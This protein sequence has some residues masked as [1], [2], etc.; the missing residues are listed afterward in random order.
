M[1]IVNI[2]SRNNNN[3]NKFNNNNWLAEQLGVDQRLNHNLHRQYSSGTNA[4]S[5]MKMGSIVEESS[6]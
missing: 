2:V 1:A 6:N 4:P 3:N 5:A